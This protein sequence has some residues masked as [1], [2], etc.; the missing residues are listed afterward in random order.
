MTRHGGPLA[1]ST[2]CMVHAWWWTID[3]RQVQF[4]KKVLI[5]GLRATPLMR[6]LVYTLW[7]ESAELRLSGVRGCRPNQLYAP[8]LEFGADE[9]NYTP[10][11]WSSGRS[12]LSAVQARRGRPPKTKIPST[13]RGRNAARR[14][15]TWSPGRGQTSKTR[16]QE[17]FSGSHT[18]I[19]PVRRPSPPERQYVQGPGRVFRKREKREMHGRMVH[20]SSFL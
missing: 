18:T 1:W 19:G 8:N 13:I 15:S 11:T 9:I 5:S 6:H 2:T 3:G 14:W 7:S 10:R 12:P 16:R 4:S 20:A 17:L